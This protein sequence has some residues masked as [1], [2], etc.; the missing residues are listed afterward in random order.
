M[1]QIPGKRLLACISGKIPQ[2][3]TKFVLYELD[4]WF[5]GR[6]ASRVRFQ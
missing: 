2:I 6:A 5:D 4:G 1:W 3:S